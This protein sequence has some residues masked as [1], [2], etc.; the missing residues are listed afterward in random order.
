MQGKKKNLCYFY[1]SDFIF[2]QVLSMSHD[3]MLEK[4][5]VQKQERI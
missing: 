4:A 2:Y 1:N 3:L 5:C